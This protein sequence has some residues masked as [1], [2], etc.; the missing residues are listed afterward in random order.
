MA[1]KNA[2]RTGLIRRLL[3]VRPFARA[4]HCCI[5]R[6]GYRTYWT[7]S[8]ALRRKFLALA[9]TTIRAPISCTSGQAFA[10][11]PLRAG[12]PANLIMPGFLAMRPSPSRQDDAIEPKRPDVLRLPL[13]GITTAHRQWAAVAQLV[14]QRIR[15]A[16]VGGSNP[17]RGTTLPC[18]SLA[19]NLPQAA[20]S[21][22]Y[23]RTNRS[24]GIFHASLIV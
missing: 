20:R 12:E 5:N 9:A 11:S 15:N 16:W 19:E 1:I 24:A 10:P 4:V 13:P 18:S 23:G 6:S 3:M 21:T 17:F 8:Q 2:M 14:E 7:D 22:L